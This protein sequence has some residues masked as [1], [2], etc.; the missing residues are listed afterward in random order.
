MTPNN[1][2]IQLIIYEE[3]RAHLQKESKTTERSLPSLCPVTINNSGRTHIVSPLEYLGWLYQDFYQGSRDGGKGR[4]SES[5][6]L[7]AVLT[8]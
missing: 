4:A 5:D 2:F 1:D 6:L 7:K 8:R 3:P